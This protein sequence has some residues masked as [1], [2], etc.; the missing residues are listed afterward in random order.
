MLAVFYSGFKNYHISQS[1]KLETRMIYGLYSEIVT[2][3]SDAKRLLTGITNNY[4]YKDIL[5]YGGIKKPD[6]LQKLVRALALQLGSKVSYN[7]LSRM[8]GAD[9]QTIENYIDLFLAHPFT[10]RNRLHRGSRRSA[11]CI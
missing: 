3:P 1:E 7:E 6:L 11:F 10:T 4:L 9:K 8:V 2:E 5:S